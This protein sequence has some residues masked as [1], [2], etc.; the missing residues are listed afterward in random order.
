MVIIASIVEFKSSE[1]ERDSGS[2]T[3]IRENTMDF[4]LVQGRKGSV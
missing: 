1:G 2:K 4:P 3:C